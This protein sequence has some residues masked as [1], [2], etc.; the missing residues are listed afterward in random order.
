M[1]C[2]HVLGPYGSRGEAHCVLPE[3]H[4]GAHDF[5]PCTCHAS[6]ERSFNVDTGDMESAPVLQAQTGGTRHDG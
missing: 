3:G 5:C 4:A 6:H 2:G 1:M